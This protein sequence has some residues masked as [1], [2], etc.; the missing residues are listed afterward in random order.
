NDDSPCCHR[1][2]APVTLNVGV[3]LAL[4]C[5]A[6]TQLGFLSKHRGGN[7][8]AAIECAK[9]RRSAR[10]LV[11]SRWFAIGLGVT[12]GAWLMHVAALAL[13]PL[14]TVQAVL[15]TG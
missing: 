2:R 12:A 6:L 13:A 4:V 3:A 15:S 5:A 9:P 11:R 7:A 10:A 1:R 8:V 14:S